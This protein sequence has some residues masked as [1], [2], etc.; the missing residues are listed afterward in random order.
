M[1][2]PRRLERGLSTVRE[3]TTRGNGEGGKAG[4]GLEERGSGTTAPGRSCG[5]VGS[6]GSTPRERDGDS[7]H[8]EE[9][10][11][12]RG[13]GPVTREGAREARR[14]ER[15]A[16]EGWTG[17]I[18]RLAAIDF[19]RQTRGLFVPLLVLVLPPPLSLS[20]PLSRHPSS[21]VSS[22]SVS[23][24]FSLARSISL[25]PLAR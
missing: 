2:F 7:G 13:E 23:L 5:C 8:A 22:P 16:R 21:L 11:L 18:R 15:G 17:W 1:R 24:S 20:F 12:V 25:C 10:G 14:G 6:P 9:Q 4:G 3:G 19:S